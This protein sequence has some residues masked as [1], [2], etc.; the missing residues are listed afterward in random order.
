MK[1][2]TALADELE[3]TLTSFMSGLPE[4]AAAT[5]KAAFE[6]LLASDVASGAVNTGDCAPD[7]EL[8]NAAGRTVRLSEQLAGGP[9]ILS[10]YRGGWCPFC[11]L[12]L[13]ALQAHLP[14]FRE[15]GAQLIAVTPESP[16][17]SLSTAEKNGL[18]F[19]VLSDAGNRVA[20]DYGLVMQVY[21]EMR[22]L[23]LQWGLDVPAYN[24]DDSWELPVP[25]TYLIDSDGTVRA[26]AVDR[27]Y[28]RRMEPSRIEA[29]LVALA[30]D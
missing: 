18:E 1:T 27:D 14:R 23:Y 3:A 7:F 29:S 9:V 25:A 5:V 24:G 4:D 15:L 30:A 16:D 20:R 10:F 8:P 28:T 19:E 11:N 26:A 6:K 13:R 21:E 12:E 17:H 22:P 2:D